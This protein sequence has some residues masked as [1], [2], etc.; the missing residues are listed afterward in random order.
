MHMFV[1]THW[2]VRYLLFL[3]TGQSKKS[4][5]T[6]FIKLKLGEIVTCPGTQSCQVAK[7][8]PLSQLPL[9]ASEM[10]PLGG[11]GGVGPETGRRWPLGA[12]SRTQES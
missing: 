1:H 11:R 6:G 3:L 12:Q 8:V 4:A 10:G 5:K 9:Q 2:V 7:A